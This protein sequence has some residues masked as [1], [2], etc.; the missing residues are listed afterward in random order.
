MRTILADVEEKIK[1][2]MPLSEAFEAQ[3]VFPKIY[4]ASI[5]AGEKSGALDDVLARYVTFLRR[6]VGLGRKIRGALA[7]PAFLMVAAVIMVSFLSLYVV[8]R[9]SDLFKALNS[10]NGLP[11]ITVIVLAVSSFLSSNIIW[12][13][14]LLIIGGAALY[15]WLRSTSGKMVLDNILLR[16]PL[17]GA[18]LKQVTTAQLARS[19][20]TL[21]SGGITVVD[22]W[23]IASQAI[24]NL[25][26]RRRSQSVLP[27]IREGQSFTDSLTKANWM[28]PL[29]MD[30]IGIG[31]RSG[32]LKE[33]LD[34][35]SQ[36][37]DAEAE[38]RLEQLT[39]LLEPF[40]LAIMAAFIV[41]IL[42]A[43]YL[44]ILQMIS[45]GPMSGN[46]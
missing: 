15:F 6:S 16:L 8:P 32:S 21:L 40:I 25:E 22:S 43:I 27:M 24:T 12:I 34:E 28:P 18:L 17:V 14:P 23:D 31:E 33:M 35:V 20:S 19:M 29:A 1:S 41:T 4:T 3:K 10:K 11:T 45:S 44:P 46:K 5:L 26:L 39:S 13:A 36:F 38:V 9:M 42:L 30:M 37:Y 2:G 7:Y